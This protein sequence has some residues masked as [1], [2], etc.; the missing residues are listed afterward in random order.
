MSCERKKEL[1]NEVGEALVKLHSLSIIHGNLNPSNI[2]I[3]CCDNIKLIDYFFTPTIHNC[4]FHEN[5]FQ[6][7]EVLLGKENNELSDSW[8][9][10]CIIYYILT[11]Q[12]LFTSKSIRSLVISIKHFS[13]SNTTKCDSP[14]FNILPYL[15][16]VSSVD[17]VTIEEALSL[18]NRIYVIIIYN[19]Y[20]T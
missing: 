5:Y 14:I 13:L 11:Q 6:S 16:N 17:R 20:R 7:L 19:Y 12:Y 9:F 15:L 2:Y 10:G 18:I 4:N 1:I 8:S 3:D